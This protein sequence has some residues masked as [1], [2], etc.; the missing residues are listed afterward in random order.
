MR[1]NGLDLNLLVVLD[2]ILTERSVSRTGEKVHL[3]QSATSAALAR[4]R[5]HFQDDLL[6]QA[7]RT[8]LPTP[9]ALQLAPEVRTVLLQ[10][11]NR[12]MTRPSFDPAA[13]KRVF[14]V[15]A[16]DYV[17]IVLLADALA[18][19]TRAAPGRSRGTPPP[20]SAHQGS[21]RRFLRSA[22]FP[23]TCMTTSTRSSE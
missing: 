11:E 1:F 16:S 13:S 9:R 14:R 19:I 23:T 22:P 4:L 21:Y 12:V 8:M 2:T 7:G 10:I 15:M 20:N 6:V 3:S 18:Q 17:T 5:D